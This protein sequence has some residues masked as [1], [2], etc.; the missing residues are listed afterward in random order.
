[1]VVDPYFNGEA[2]DAYLSTAQPGLVI[3][4]LADRYS[5]DIRGYVERHKAQ[6]QTHIELR[7]SRELHDRLVFV[8]QDTC[9]IMG[10]SIKDAGKKA[11]YLIPAATQI[12]KA[13]NSIY[14]EIWA[15]AANPEL[16]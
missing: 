7:R 5:N 16:S 15:R 9:W 2:F 3:R 10:G 8:D 11:T 1:M 4:I 13:K 14:A 6:F 12:A